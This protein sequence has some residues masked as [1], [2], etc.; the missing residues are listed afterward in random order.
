MQELNKPINPFVNPLHVPYIEYITNTEFKHSELLTY[1]FEVEAETYM[2]LYVSKK[3]REFIF[4]TLSPKA[5]EIFTLLLYVTNPEYQY[6]LLPFD[7]VQESFNG[8]SRRRYEDAIRELIKYSVIDIRSREDSSFW[9]NPIYFASDNRLNMFPQ[10]KVK[11]K[12][13]RVNPKPLD[14]L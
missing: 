8:Y 5:R 4:G 1:G 3:R 13:V 2:R 12:S 6:T 11:I 9:Y 14:S 7:K 10:C